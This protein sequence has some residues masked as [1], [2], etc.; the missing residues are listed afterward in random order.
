MID[1]LQRLVQIK[2][3]YNFSNYLF[4][5]EKVNQFSKINTI[6]IVFCEFDLRS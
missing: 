1:D 6:S 3:F 4:I 5:Q 2:S